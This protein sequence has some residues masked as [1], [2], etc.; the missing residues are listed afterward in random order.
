MNIKVKFNMS[1]Y[2]LILSDNPEVGIIYKNIYYLNDSFKHI[3]NNYNIIRLVNTTKYNF[4]IYFAYLSS[5][6]EHNN[7]ISELIEKKLLLSRKRYS[8]LKL[9]LFCDL[10]I[11]IDEIDVKLKYKIETYGFKIWYNKIIIQEVKQLKMQKISYLDYFIA[12][13]INN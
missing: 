2:N 1:G 3:E 9:I 6:D 11:N 12:Y 4:I 13:D 5:N 8:G 10:N 7:K